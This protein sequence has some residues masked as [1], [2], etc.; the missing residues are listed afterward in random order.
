MSKL[1]IMLLGPPSI[2]IDGQAITFESRKIMAL[3]AYQACKGA[4][5]AVPRSA[6][7]ALLWPDSDRARALGAL[8]YTLSKVRNQ[9]DD[10]WLNVERSQVTLR[11]QPGLSIDVA[12]FRKLVAQ[13]RDNN[14]GN[15]VGDDRNSRLTHAAQLYRG[16]FLAGFGL[17]DSEQFDEWQFYQA[18][19]LQRDLA[20][21]LE[22]LIE[23]QQEQGALEQA[24][25]TAERRLQLDTLQEK[26]W[27]KI[28]ELHVAMDQQALALKQYEECVNV[29]E[30]ELGVPPSGETQALYAQ[31]VGGRSYSALPGNHLGENQRS[32]PHNL[33]APATPFLGREL[34]LQELQQLLA[35]PDC[36]LLTIHGLG[37]VGKTRLLRQI[38]LG[39]LDP[40]TSPFKDGVY[41][42]SLAST[43]SRMRLVMAIADAVR[44][45]VSSSGDLWTQLTEYLSTRSILLLLD[46]FEQLTEVATELADLLGAAPGLKLA[47]TSRERL[48]LYEEW[49]YEI[50]G[51]ELPTAADSNEL[52]PEDAADFSAVRLFVQCARRVNP[53]LA[54]DQELDHV[55]A[56]CRLVDGVPLAIEL[57][58]G[59]LQFMACDEI[60]AR[61][62]HDLGFLETSLRNV[63]ERH[64]SLRAVF[65]Y[66]WACLRPVEQAVFKRISVF[67]GGFSF[68]AAARISDASLLLLSQ[69][70]DKSMLS[71]G[72]SSQQDGRFELHELLR[73]F[74]ADFLSED[75]ERIIRQN[76]A[77]YFA[78]FLCEQEQY[79]RHA[80]ESEALAA[81]SEEI[82]NVRTGWQW[83]VGE[84]ADN[85]HDPAAIEIVRRY[86]RML[87]YY[88]LQMGRYPDGLQLLEEASR[89]L[90]YGL[91][92]ATEQFH[93]RRRLRLL[94]TRAVVQTQL[95]SLYV[96]LAEYDRV[97]ELAEQ[98]IPVLRQY[99][100]W[101]VLADALI[102]LGRAHVR[103]G[104]Y[105]ETYDAVT[106]ATE[107][108]DDLGHE[109]NLTQSLNLLGIMYAN[110]GAFDQALEQYEAC[111]NIHRKHNYREG[112]AQSLNNLGTTVARQGAYARSKRFYQSAFELAESLDNNELLKAVILSN[113]GSSSRSLEQYD[114]A[115]SY[116]LRSL[117]ISRR[118]KE[119][120]WNAASLNGLGDTMVRI[121][122][123]KN[124]EEILFEALATAVDIQT[125]PDALDAIGAIGHLLLEK[126]NLKEAVKVLSFTA[127]HPL[128]VT[129]NRERSQISLRRLQHILDADV[130]RELTTSVEGKGIEEMAAY[131]LGQPG[132]KRSVE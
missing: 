75:E 113:L 109:S 77:D 50:G 58:A 127:N 64:R 80:E 123:L 11:D 103:K 38:G 92:S 94:V 26:A 56:I 13:L 73:Q 128:S 10:Q 125:Q 67:R 101:D 99:E 2:A 76:H 47:V 112:M 59:W 40:T 118:L 90:T 122:E 111:L 54:V 22:Q 115:Q 18:E 36:R 21:V 91:A 129:V 97:L 43:E 4:G 24:L 70:Q 19:S 105:L 71:R 120:R 78:Q 44:L 74:A 51:L 110:Q 48:Q 42:V 30:R 68:R 1:E 61:I 14:V 31:I 33:Q 107:I 85:P 69:L 84:L 60:A 121:G 87:T 132:N 57:A 89:L 116:Y 124:A 83:V 126:G 32:I 6:L 27:R 55:L 104:H 130:V 35:D 17:R 53:R 79:I 34:E 52:L 5:V 23:Y 65:E 72:H 117:E 102:N 16:D 86:V 45:T 41:F 119:R 9:I 7:A 20:W 88:Y 96:R 108:Y 46:N 28:M 114:D 62:E 15:N 29:L 98:C 100:Q 25:E 49:L 39:Y 12:G 37:G 3:L 106:E 131:L 82:E 66:S 63:P 93:K 95:T 8:R 81:I